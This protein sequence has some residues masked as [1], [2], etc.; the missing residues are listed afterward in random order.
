MHHC[1]VNCSPKL[2]WLEYRG[3][4]RGYLCEG[5]SYQV[6]WRVTLEVAPRV[7]RHEDFVEADV[8]P[9][10]RL[11]LLVEGGVLC[12]DVVS[13]VPASPVSPA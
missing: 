3:W 8:G 7:F 11:A 2:E 9:R 4:R 12:L 5:G 13:R 1:I 6:Y 10:S